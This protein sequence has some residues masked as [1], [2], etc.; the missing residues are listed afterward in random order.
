MYE[1]QHVIHELKSLLKPNEPDYCFASKTIE[2]DKSS[3]PSNNTDGTESLSP[4]VSSNDESSVPPSTKRT[5][6]SAPLGSRNDEPSAPPSAGGNESVYTTVN[7]FLNV[8]SSMGSLSQRMNH[9]EEEMLR[10]RS[11]LVRRIKE[12]VT[13]ATRSRSN[14][15]SSTSSGASLMCVSMIDFKND[16]KTVVYD[17]ATF[18]WM[19]GIL[20]RI[21][22]E[23]RLKGH[24]TGTYLVRTSSSSSE[25]VLSIVNGKSIMHYIIYGDIRQGFGLCFIKSSDGTITIVP[26]KKPSIDELLLHFSHHHIDKHT[27]LLTTPCP[28]PKVK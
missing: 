9:G 3:S 18:D 22:T 12:E 20:T 13:E 28:R 23:E 27:P 25:S 6:S 5:E 17:D 4:L 24:P 16:V 11:P 10:S 2:H 1:E 21:E 7:K 26:P 19:H 14:S 8:N 15:I